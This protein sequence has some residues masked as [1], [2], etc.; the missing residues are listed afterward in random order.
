MVLFAVILVN[1]TLTRPSP[2]DIAFALALAM[3]PFCAQK[4]TRRGIVFLAL[5]VAWWT[6]MM[7]SSWPHSYD[8]DVVYQLTK[9]SY[10]ISIGITAC[11][12]SM[13]WTRDQV[14]RLFQFWIFS[15][16]IAATLATIGF[17]LQIED[18][19]WDG[20]GKAFLDDPNMYAA[21]VLPAFLGCIYFILT[22]RNR[23]LY[24]ALLGL[25]VVGLLVAFSRVAIA[26]A[27]GTGLALTVILNRRLLVKTSTALFIVG[28]LAVAVGAVAI[29]SF[30]EFA[31]KLADRATLAKDYDSGETGRLA[32]YLK[33]FNLMLDHPEGMGVLQFEKIFPEP[34]H[35]FWLG[36]FVNYGWLAGFAWTFIVYFGLALTIRNY[37]HTGDNLMLLVFLSWLAIFGCALLHEAERW[38][39]LWFFTGIMW[40][41]TARN[42]PQ[43]AR[44][45]EPVRAGTAG[46]QAMPVPSALRH[47]QIP[48]H[49]VRGSATGTLT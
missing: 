42:W 23:K 26:A 18:L 6:G 9:T 47:Q 10:A 46:P 17:A 36:S 11:L 30:P 43:R 29:L 7:V 22:G 48:L 14:E 20:R 35:N 33:S 27:L 15:A 21:F 28:A 39:H 4:M 8:E 25:M 5:I 44:V 2:V 1:F 34:I 37:R 12:V 40:G 19:V 49:G 31:E 45:P 3:T 13:H 38:R 32:R 24:S 16:S 41:V